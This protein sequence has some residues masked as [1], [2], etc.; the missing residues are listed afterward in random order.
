MNYSIGLSALD[1]AQRALDVIGN[2][3][4]NAGT[5]G[6]HRQRVE[7]DP[8]FST[9]SGGILL[10]GGVNVEGV[11]KTLLDKNLLKILGRKYAPGRPIT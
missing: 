3:I 6:Y 7:L 4:A 2:N 1:A 8:A 5:D 10:G 11:L 9:Q